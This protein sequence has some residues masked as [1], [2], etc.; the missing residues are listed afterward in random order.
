MPPAGGDNRQQAA[1]W[2]N[3]LFPPAPAQPPAAAPPRGPSSSFPAPQVPDQPA[4]EGISRL[5]V[6]GYVSIALLV[7]LLGA[8]ALYYTARPEPP[9]YK[10]GTCVR[11]DGGKAVEAACSETGA[12]R[13]V[14]KVSDHAKC[15]NADQPYATLPGG[16]VLC[17]KP[18]S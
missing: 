16:S 18:K 12:Y 1:A 10:V 17:L 8:G 9:T 3:Q 11:E 7:V 4:V 2:Q 15:P 6:I 13:I 5:R 14:S